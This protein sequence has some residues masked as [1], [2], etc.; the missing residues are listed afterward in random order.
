[1][2]DAVGRTM[3]EHPYT[4]TTLLRRSWP[5]NE[6]NTINDR[7]VHWKQPAAFAFSISGGE[8]FISAAVCQSNSALSLKAGEQKFCQ[9]KFITS[10]RYEY[11]SSFVIFFNNDV[12]LF[13]RPSA[14]HSF[15]IISAAREGTFRFGCF[16]D[17]S[18]S[19]V[20]IARRS[21]SRF[22]KLLVQL[23]RC[24]SN[25]PTLFIRPA[26]RCCVSNVQG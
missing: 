19:G 11:K 10:T 24:S 17:S 21:Q 25:A 23:M 15:V 5:H 26:H 2:L 20:P 9:S 6:V 8:S 16:C 13:R 1:L 18:M 4:D 3:G 12:E 7:H 22:P 14:P